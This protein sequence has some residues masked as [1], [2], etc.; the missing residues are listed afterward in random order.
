[1][2]IRGAKK[3]LALKNKRVREAEGKFL[4]EGVRLCEEALSS[5]ANVEQVLFAREAMD[6]DRLGRLMAV[7][8]GAGARPD[9]DDED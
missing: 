9:A 2:A 1:M 5:P 8:V 7:P 4:I 3:I 6:S